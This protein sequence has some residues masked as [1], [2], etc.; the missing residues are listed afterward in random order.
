LQEGQAVVELVLALPAL[1]V[2]A[3]LVLAGARLLGASIAL[4]DAARAGAVAA[5]AD[6]AR[7][8]AGQALQDATAAALAEGIS[9]TCSGPGVP[10]G[11]VAVATETGGSSGKQMEVVTVYDQVD[12][13]FPGLPP[14]QIHQ[15]AA[16][17]P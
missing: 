3:M 7:G 11:C 17:T 16:A 13:G 12:T 8:Q 10:A 9:V 15:Q 14:I 1:V 4:A 2:V 6:V 5:A